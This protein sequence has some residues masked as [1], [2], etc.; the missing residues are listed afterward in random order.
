VRQ[1]EGDLTLWRHFAEVDYPVQEDLASVAF[2]I[3]TS[4]VLTSNMKDY[5]A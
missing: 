2:D 4:E 3:D 5:V 1:L